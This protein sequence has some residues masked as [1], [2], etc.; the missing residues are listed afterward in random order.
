MAIAQLIGGQL[1]QAGFIRLQQR[2]SKRLDVLIDCSRIGGFGMRYSIVQQA[3]RD[4]RERARSG[5]VTTSYL[6]AFPLGITDWIDP[7]FY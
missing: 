1:L 5:Q 2:L 6:H 4:E 3:R 7:R